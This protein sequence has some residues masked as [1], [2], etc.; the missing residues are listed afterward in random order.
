MRFAVLVAFL[1]GV[2][3]LQKLGRGVGARRATAQRRRVAATVRI[4][5]AYRVMRPRRFRI[6]TIKAM[7][8]A[9]AYIRRSMAKRAAQRARSEMKD[10][11][12]LQTEA[13]AMKE[14]IQQLRALS[15]AHA[16]AELLSHQ[17]AFLPLEGC[18]ASP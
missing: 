16:E 6:K 14:E 9:Q 11:A 5:S 7:T 10:V 4:Q 12:N 18:Q 17:Q 13:E 15:R 2:L 1:C 3:A 8:R